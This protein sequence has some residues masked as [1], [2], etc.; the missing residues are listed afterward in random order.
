LA[1]SKPSTPSIWFGR[2]FP[3]VQKRLGPAF[4][5]SVSVGP[6]GVK[7]VTPVEM[8]LDFM[9]G[10]LGGDERLQHRVIWFQPEQTFFFYDPRIKIFAPTS[11]EKLKMLTSQ[12]ILKCAQEMPPTVNIQLL[13][14]E[15][16]SEETLREVVKRAKALLEA[17][18]SFFSP[19][20][21][22]TRLRGPETHERLARVFIKQAIK[23]EPQEIL[24]VSQ[25]FELFC[26]FSK[27][28]GVEPLN[29]R[30]FRPMLTNLIREEFDLGFRKDLLGPQ[31]KYAAGWKGLCAQLPVHDGRLRHK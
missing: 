20:S 3:S 18:E 2:K 5:E 28:C 19:E 1:E 13:F 4:L 31:N 30:H 9:A 11:E 6:D 10:A 17:D 21:P 22:N 23:P 25:C 14:T 15:S 12:L 27:A 16:R 7:R 24:T 29:R 8:N 26:A